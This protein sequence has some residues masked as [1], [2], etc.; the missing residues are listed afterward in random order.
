MS[1]AD[2]VI[3]DL[4]MDR[5]R[6][7][8]VPL[9]DCAPI[10]VARELGLF[11]KWGLEVAISREPSWANIRDKVAIGALDGA[12]MLAALPLASALGLG[13]IAKPL[14]TALNLGLNGNAITLS[15]ALWQQILYAHPAAAVERPLTAR[16][17]RTVIEQRKSV[18][19]PPLTFAV[20]FPFSSHNYLPRYWLA[21]GGIDPDRDVRLTV[22]PPPLMVAKLEARHID[23]F[24]VGAPWNQ[25]AVE[26]G[27]GRIAVCSYEIWHNHPEKVFGVTR[28]WAERHP[29]THRALL[30]AII[31]A[32]EWLDEPANRPEAARI[33]VSRGYVD[34]PESIVA[35]SLIGEIRYGHDEAPRISRDYIVFHRYAAN[36]PWLSHAEWTL[37]QMQRWGQIGD[38]TDIASVAAAA[39]RPDIFRD[40]A[41][42]L[43][44]S[45]PVFDRKREGDH[46]GGW[47]LPG[48]PDAI[49]MGADTFIDDQIFDPADTAGYLARVRH[50]HRIDAVSRSSGSGRPS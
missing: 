7:G 46:I 45:C 26:L 18:G 33:L 34:V 29:N 36:F 13:G 31:E 47:M 40:V 16:G 8:I 39:Y 9:T 4:E 17:L 49:A 14:L 6:L 20:T 3:G 12:Q 30:A 22:V 48:S 37:V 11:R 35:R 5:V 1:G 44:R 2:D 32:A 10:A 42:R 38:A 50:H 28:D 15:A 24:C 23:G 41:A 25:R 43:G 21:A 27:I 19:A